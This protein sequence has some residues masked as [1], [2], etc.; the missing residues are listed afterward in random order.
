MRKRR[1]WGEKPDGQ[2][3]E[4]GRRLERRMDL[5]RHCYVFIRLEVYNSVY[6][7]GMYETMLP[8]LY[9]RELFTARGQKKKA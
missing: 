1:E 9:R 2:H 6:I 3:G 4:V 8:L 5:T 7:D